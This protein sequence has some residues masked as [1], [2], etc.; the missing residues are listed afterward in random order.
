MPTRQ[1]IAVTT[2]HDTGRPTRRGNS[3]P[4]RRDNSVPARQGNANLPRQ[5]TAMSGRQ[6]NGNPP[7]QGTAMSARQGNAVPTLRGDSVPTLRGDSILAGNDDVHRQ[8]ELP[9]HGIP[10][11]VALR[12]RAMTEW[13]RHMYLRHEGYSTAD[14]EAF[15]REIMEETKALQEFKEQTKEKAKKQTE[16]G[17]KEDLISLAG[18]NE[19]IDYQPALLG[20]TTTVH[21]NVAGDATVAWQTALLGD[22]SRAR[23]KPPVAP[24]GGVGLLEGL[25]VDISEPTEMGAGAKKPSQEKGKASDE[26][27]PKK[28]EVVNIMDM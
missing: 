16:K 6:G 28:K 21:A 3:V 5:G 9:A 2:R 22:A 18:D 15:E 25:L 24:V 7:H 27:K 23:S 4:A 11:E 17:V 19:T 12:V 14:A 13:E 10:I 1:D 20:D 8:G 26:E